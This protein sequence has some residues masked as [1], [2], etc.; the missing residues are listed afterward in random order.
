MP[1]VRQSVIAPRAALDG[2]LRGARALVRERAPVALVLVQGESVAARRV[3]E[4]TQAVAPFPASARPLDL[5]VGGAMR[6]AITGPNG[7]GKSSLLRMFAGTLAPLSGTCRAL[8]PQAWLDQHASLAPAQ[9]Q[10]VLEQLA[11]LETAFP[12][13]ALRSH[14]ALLGRSAA[15]LDAPVSGL[16]CG[17]RLKA[18]LACANRRV[19]CC[20]TSPPITLTWRR[21]VRWKRRC[22]RIAAHWRW[23]RT[24]RAF[25]PVWA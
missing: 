23:C 17:E 3:L 11:A 12:P 6:F 4:L 25:S 21:C 1:A 22:K 2:A 10:S 24:M 14:L 20:S 7:C 9:H 16:S 8:A 5:V 19:C 15:Q 13:S 18:A